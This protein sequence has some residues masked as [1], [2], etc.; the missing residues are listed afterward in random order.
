[1][2]EWMVTDILS[3]LTYGTKATRARRSPSAGGIGP[4]KIPVAVSIVGIGVAG[5][6]AAPRPKSWTVALPAISCPELIRGTTA[7]GNS[8]DSMV[9]GPD[10]ILLTSKAVTP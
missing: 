2:I 3:L 1:M 8:P 4:L 7:W 10:R 9:D 6:G 5:S